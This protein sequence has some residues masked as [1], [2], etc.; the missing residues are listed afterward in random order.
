[1]SEMLAAASPPAA[2]MD[3]NATGAPLLSPAR[4]REVVLPGV[5][6]VKGALDAP[7]QERALRWCLARGPC[8]S[9]LG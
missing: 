9:S 6:L 4:S 7:R 8:S 2:T 1:M 5:V 3:A